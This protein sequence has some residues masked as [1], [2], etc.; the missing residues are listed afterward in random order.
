MRSARS[1]S[2]GPRA[3]RRRAA[4]PQPHVE[5]GARVVHR[6]RADP[7][8]PG[9]PQQQRGGQRRLVERGQHHG[10]GATPARGSAR[11]PRP[12]R[13]G[14][15]GG[16]GLITQGA[17][18]TRTRRTPGSSPA[19]SAPARPAQQA[20]LGGGRH[21]TRPRDRP[22]A[23]R[24]PRPGATA[25]TPAAHGWMP[26]ARGRRPGRSF[27]TTGASAIS[28]GRVAG[29]GTRTASAP[30]APSGLDVGADVA[31]HRRPLR[32]HAQGRGGGQ[33]H[34]RAGLAAPAP[35][36]GPVRADLPG[37]ERTEQLRPPAR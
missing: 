6:G 9:Q 11:S 30:A 26:A 13:R 23:R 22:A 35:V 24:R 28:C 36:G 1:G 34:P 4:G 16:A 20:H 21:R 37:V 14:R 31:D 33:H 27:R 17:G 19:A 10:L 2:A 18:Q 25:S 29:V 12:R 7:T 3:G 15:T 32:G 8:D 5:Q